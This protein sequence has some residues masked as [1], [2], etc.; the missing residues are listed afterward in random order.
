MAARKN[1]HNGCFGTPP[2]VNFF[3]SVDEDVSDAVEVDK[4]ALERELAE[5]MKRQTVSGSD[6]KKG[7]LQKD[8]TLSEL[9]LWFVFFMFFMVKSNHNEKP[10][11]NVSLGFVINYVLF[12]C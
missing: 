10:E 11:K 6:V 4:D 9:F 5:K 3:S 7:D 8:W 12:L 2:S 1:P